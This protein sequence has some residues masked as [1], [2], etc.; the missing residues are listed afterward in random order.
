MALYYPAKLALADF[1]GGNKPAN[2]NSNWDFVQ[3]FMRKRGYALRSTDVSCLCTVSARQ[4][5]F[6]SCARQPV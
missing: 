4:I 6:S 2:K 5:P 1:N 3:K